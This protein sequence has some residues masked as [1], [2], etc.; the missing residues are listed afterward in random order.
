M[1]TTAKAVRTTADVLRQQQQDHGGAVVPLAKSAPAAVN[2]G[3]SYLA[4]HASSGTVLR[5]S[6]DGKFYRPTQGDA[7]LPEGTELVCHWDQACAG[8]QRFNG[9]GERPDIRID[10][11]FGGKPPE[12]SE[13]GDDDASQWPISDLS[14]K[15]E[16][17]WREVQMVPLESIE[18]GE[19]FVF[20]TMSVT[21][22]RAVANVLRQSSRM[23]AKDPDHLPVIKLRAGGF[24]HRKFGWV[25]VPAFEFVG[26]APKTN[27]AAATTAI[28]ADLN[29]EVP[30]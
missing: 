5:F 23:A 6:K 19:I 15:P 28:A 13:L 18:T 30:F 10:L 7:E 11:I 2:D 27:I 22:L 26:K 25:R 16:D 21:G 14:G 12:R 9:K 29:D 4:K 1:E 3:L 24:D 17:P 8:Y 20:Q